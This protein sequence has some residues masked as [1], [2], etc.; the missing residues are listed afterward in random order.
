MAA[1]GTF[2]LVPSPPMRESL[3]RDY[4]AMGG[5]IFGP[6]PEIDDVLHVIE[7]LEP[8][9]NALDAQVR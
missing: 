6:L 9:L 5:M 3:A 7:A 1:H 8:R 4:V 2:T